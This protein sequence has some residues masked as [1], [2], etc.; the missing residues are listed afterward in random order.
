MRNLVSKFMRLLKS[1]SPTESWKSLSWSFALFVVVNAFWM[2]TVVITVEKLNSYILFYALSVVVIFGFLLWVVVYSFRAC[3]RDGRDSRD[4]STTFKQAMYTSL[5]IAGI[6]V[7]LFFLAI[8][9]L[10]RSHDW[11]PSLYE[12]DSQL[13]GIAGVVLLLPLT[14]WLGWMVLGKRVYKRYS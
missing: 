3:V 12:L 1:N 5:S 14:L 11:F 6:G 10:I 9:L 7:P 4:L 8:E 13:V 2:L